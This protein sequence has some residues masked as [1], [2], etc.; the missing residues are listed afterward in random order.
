MTDYRELEAAIELMENR[1]KLIPAPA[2]RLFF[3]KCPECGKRIWNSL[4][5]TELSYQ[6]HYMDAHHAQL[7]R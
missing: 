1:E 4:F 7:P 6:I 2:V 5:T 3:L